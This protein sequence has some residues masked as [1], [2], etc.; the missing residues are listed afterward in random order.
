[1]FFGDMRYER[2]ER[3]MRD[4]MVNY[5]KYHKTYYGSCERYN[6]RGERYF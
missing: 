5:E 2:Y 3:I 1:M 6:E 4:T